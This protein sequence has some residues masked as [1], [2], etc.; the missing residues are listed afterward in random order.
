MK[1]TTQ[2]P[3]W[4]SEAYNRAIKRASK[5]TDKGIRIALGH[6]QSMKHEAREAYKDVLR[7][8][9]WS[10]LDLLAMDI[11]FQQNYGETEQ[12]EVADFLGH[13]EDK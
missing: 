8:R 3:E 11:D 10:D 9:G 4:N 7:H 13:K 6:E 5:L 12:P 1:Q 2:I